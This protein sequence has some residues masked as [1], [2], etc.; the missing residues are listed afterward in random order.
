MSLYQTL[1]TEQT[2]E[3]TTIDTDTMAHIKYKQN[4]NFLAYLAIHICQEANGDYVLKG[5]ISSIYWLKYQMKCCTKM[6]FLFVNRISPY[7]TN[8]KN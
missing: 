8:E 5:S 3:S 1:N 7:S 6:L 2:T 4:M